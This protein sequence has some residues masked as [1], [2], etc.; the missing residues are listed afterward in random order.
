MHYTDLPEF[1]HELVALR[2]LSRSDAAAW[3]AYLTMPHVLDHT[4]WDLRSVDELLQKFD[5]LEL[6]D[7]ASEMRLAIV[8]RDSGGLVGTIG[9]HSVS[10]LH[11]TVEIAYD[12]APAVWGKGIASMAC[13]A[14]AEWGF[15]RLGAVRIQAAV[16]DS[17]TRSARV[18]EKC[19][20]QCEGLL[21]SFRMVRGRPRDF[22]IY[23][24]LNPHSAVAET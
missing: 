14:M 8:L 11:K 22:W 3:Y 21:R 23:S 18:L 17:N 12:L 6:P 10:P 1:I 16:L 4:S 15:S 7:P 24:R 9:F 5:A 19:G 20:F 2:P 13:S